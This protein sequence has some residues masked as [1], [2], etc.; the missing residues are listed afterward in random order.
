MEDQKY[1]KPDHAPGR[2]GGS[3]QLAYRLFRILCA[4]IPLALGG[5]VIWQ[6]AHVRIGE[7]VIAQS[8]LGWFMS[9]PVSQVHD[10]VFFSWVGGPVIGM[11]ISQ[12]CTVAYLLGPMCLLAA[13]MTALTKARLLR[14]ASGLLIGAGLLIIVNQIRVAIIAMSTQHW[15]ISG[16]DVSHKLVGTLVALIGFTIAASVMI[17]V[18]TGRHDRD[19]HHRVAR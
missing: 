6:Q 14:L 13:L 10:I 15:G 2:R 3:T 18:S 7:A 17:I 19:G 8:W 1:P 5:L 9:G 4:C 16:Y 11:Q 12:E